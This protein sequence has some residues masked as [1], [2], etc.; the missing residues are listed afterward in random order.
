[1]KNYKIALVLPFTALLFGAAV[2]RQTVAQPATD[3]TS[4]KAPVVEI[5][6]TTT[7]EAPKP[8]ETILEAPQRLP[9]PQKKATTPPQGCWMDLAT[10][11][12][13]PADTLAN[14]NYIIN[15]ESGCDPTAYNGKGLDRSYGLLQINTITPL[16][17][18][19]QKTCGINQPEELLN[20]ETNLKCGL[21]YYLDQ[22]WRPW[23][24]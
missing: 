20:P 4:Y 15:R 14:L 2:T 10:K 12:G 1:M 7:T 23:H 13:W 3:V 6:T 16:W 17:G 21:Q 19:V 18:Y 8:A 5:S 9:E 24:T 11:V 22:G